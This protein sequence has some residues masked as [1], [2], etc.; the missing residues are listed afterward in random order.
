M[1]GQGG[2]R[3]SRN[4]IPRPEPGN[5]HSNSKPR[6]GRTNGSHGC[7]PWNKGIS[8]RIIGSLAYEAEPPGK[9]YQARAC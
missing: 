9:H 2:G 4:C 7:N 5:E 1:A 8:V 3:A 6:K